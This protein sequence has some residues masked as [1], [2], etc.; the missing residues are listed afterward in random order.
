MRN[1]LF[2]RRNK[3]FHVGNFKRYCL[4]KSKSIAEDGCFAAKA[5]CFM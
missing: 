5:Y 2:R 4:Y 1:F 3:K